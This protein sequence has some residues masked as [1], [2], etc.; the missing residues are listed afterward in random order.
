MDKLA[1]GPAPT[2]LRVGDT[3]EWANHDILRHSATASDRSFDVDL[4]PGAKRRMKLKRPGTIS[5]FCRYHPGMK[6]QIVVTK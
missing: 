5:Y 6:G 4:N 3:L 2:G 1:F